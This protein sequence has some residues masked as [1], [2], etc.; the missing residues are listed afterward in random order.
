MKIYRIAG[1]TWR[2]KKDNTILY[3]A[4]PNRL[5]QIGAMS[6]FDGRSGAFFSP[7]YR[8]MAMDWAPWV[9]DKKNSSHPLKIQWKE[10]WKRIE[11]LEDLSTRTPQED[12]ELQSLENKIEK[13]RDSFENVDKQQKG[14]S[15]VFV[16]KVA[17]PNEIFEKYQ[18][19]FEQKQNEKMNINNWGFWGW[20]DQVFIDRED[21]PKLKIVKVEKWEKP[22]LFDEEK[23]AWQNRERSQTGWNESELS[24]PNIPVPQWQQKDQ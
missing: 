15:K 14:Y 23:K 3:H 17:C 9:L 12:V 2:D 7:T 16:H 10:I 5:S 13:L 18:K 1:K 6:T 19:R 20:G 22:K 21:L 24:D 4:S 8:S 11:I